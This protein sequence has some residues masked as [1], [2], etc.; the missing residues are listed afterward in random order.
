MT[1]FW[2]SHCTYECE[3][4][5]IEKEFDIGEWHKLPREAVHRF[6]YVLDVD[7]NTFSGRYLGLLKSGSLVFKVG[8]DNG[9]FINV[10]SV[11]HSSTAQ[12]TAFLEY[13]SDWLRP[14]EHYI[15][16][17]VD[18]SDLVDRVQWAIDNDDEAR[19][20]QQQGMWFAEAV[21]TDEQNDCYFAAVLLEWARLW[22]M[23]SE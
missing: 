11:T 23:A 2:G 3:S 9:K 21:L 10:H 1:D 22:D 16:V 6:K 20:I 12:S 14:Y 17:K 8:F 13:F 19:R 18:L 4:E 5:P 7:G 15:P